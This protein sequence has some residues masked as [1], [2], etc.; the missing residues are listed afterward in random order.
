MTGKSVNETGRVRGAGFSDAAQR[1]AKK[2]SAPGWHGRSDVLPWSGYIVAQIVF[3]AGC[4]V[5]IVSLEISNLNLSRGDSASEDVKRKLKL[6][7]QL[8]KIF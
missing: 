6:G 4:T 3:S 7:S 2:T 5:R 1:G 8:Q